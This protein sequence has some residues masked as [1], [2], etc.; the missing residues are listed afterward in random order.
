M[1][2]IKKIILVLIILV[3][4]INAI[5][6]SQV[7]FAGGAVDNTSIGTIAWVNPTLAIGGTNQT[8]AQATL[9][10]QISHYLY[11]TNYAFSIPINATIDGVVVTPMRKSDRTSNGGSRDSAVR[12]I[13]NSVIG[14]VDRATA[15]IYTITDTVE[16]HGGNTDTWGVT[17]TPAII[18]SA[19]FGV[20]F[21]ATKASS[22]GP[23]HVID[24][25]FIRITV[26]YTLPSSGTVYKRKA[27]PQSVY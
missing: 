14:S 24:V 7:K 23:V 11:L 26:Y 20:A 15:T 13:T 5:A 3:S 21:A 27:K 6:D 9:N 4:V 8:Y 12:L 1:S 10:G 22:S 25:D 19:R 16:D 17:L 2:T 18:N